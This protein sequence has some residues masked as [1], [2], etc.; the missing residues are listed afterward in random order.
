MAGRGSGVILTLSASRVRVRSGRLRVRLRG[1]V[2]GHRGPHETVRG[3]ARTIRHTC[4]LAAVGGDPGELGGR[5]DRR[6]VRADGGDRSAYKGPVLTGAGDDVGRRGK[7]GG[8]S[9][10]GSGR[11][12]DR[13]RLQ[14]DQR[15]GHQLVLFPIVVSTTL[16][17]PL[18][19]NNSPLI[20]GKIAAL[21]QQ[22]GKNI[23]VLGS[24]KRLFEEGGDQKAL[25]LVES[26]TFGTGV[27]FL[28]YRPVRE[29]PGGERN[30]NGTA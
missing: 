3:G 17:E 29:E 25:E 24:G 2:R 13:N 1:R 28:T 21:K 26:R 30:N 9:G 14:P 22:P 20:K 23:T 11:C 5:F 6:L 18:D 4:E 27:V 7:R 16:E 12:D 10:L 8:V 19:W 15:H